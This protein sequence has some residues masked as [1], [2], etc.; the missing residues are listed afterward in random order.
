VIRDNGSPELIQTRLHVPT[1]V[2]AGLVLK[3]LLPALD[4][5]PSEFLLCGCEVKLSPVLPVLDVSHRRYRGGLMS[6]SAG[7]PLQA[8]FLSDGMTSN[9]IQNPKAADVRHMLNLLDNAV[10]SNGLIPC[11]L[12][13]PKIIYIS[14]IMFYVTGN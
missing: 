1:T 5:Q 3:Q 12:Q 14:Q 8:S 9:F 4:I 10:D 11:N 13:Q 6:V 7:L 2:E